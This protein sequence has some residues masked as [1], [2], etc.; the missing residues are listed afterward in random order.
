LVPVAAIAEVVRA[1]ELG[2]LPAGCPDWVLG[3][4]TWRDQSV[5]V[6]RL[7]T[8]AVPDNRPN[9][10]VVCLAPSGDAAL[11]YLAIASIDLPRVERLITGCVAPWQNESHE[12]PWYALT[13]LT[14]DQR[15]AWLLDLAALER[16]LLTPC[17]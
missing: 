8:L 2:P 15:P 10:M 14:I 4:L 5:P 13:G 17:A 12:V 7:S 9:T 3:T 16:E 1:Q 11:R 6:A